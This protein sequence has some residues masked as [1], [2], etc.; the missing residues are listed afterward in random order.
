MQTKLT[1]K[2]QLEKIEREL[3][4]EAQVILGLFNKAKS[5]DETVAISMLAGIIEYLT[6]KQEGN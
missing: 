1:P 4:D 5:I 6:E 3:R 2:E